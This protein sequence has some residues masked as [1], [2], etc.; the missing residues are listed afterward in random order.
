M[1]KKGKTSLPVIDWREYRDLPGL[2]IKSV[3]V[4]VDSGALMFFV[5]SPVFTQKHP[6]AQK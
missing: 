3:K 2:G 4:N 6:G 5:N 1:T